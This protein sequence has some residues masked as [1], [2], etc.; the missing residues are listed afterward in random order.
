MTLECLIFFFGLSS[1]EKK[2]SLK[3]EWKEKGLDIPDDLDVKYDNRFDS[4]VITP[5]T[6][7]MQRLS[8]ALQANFTISAS[9]I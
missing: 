6:E 2:E 1:A 7:F 5:G 4:N 8:I 9:S 3:N